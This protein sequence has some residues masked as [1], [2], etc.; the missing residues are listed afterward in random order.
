MP[1]AGAG[2]TR[3]CCGC[4]EHQQEAHLIERALAVGDN[5]VR[6]VE[7]SA[8]ACACTERWRPTELE[9]RL[10]AV[11]EALGFPANRHR[12]EQEVVNDGT[13]GPPLHRAHAERGV[14]PDCGARCTCAYVTRRV[15]WAKGTYDQVL[16]EALL[17]IARRRLIRERRTIKETAN[18]LGFATTTS[19]HRA[20]KRWTGL[21]PLAFCR[22][23]DRAPR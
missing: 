3:T 15:Y 10:F 21:T 9:V 16:D 18:A 22:R 6:I 4:A 5:F 7:R 13:P 1:A 17:T 23:Y 8:F 14:E 11:L 12:V 19:F 2:R 20:F